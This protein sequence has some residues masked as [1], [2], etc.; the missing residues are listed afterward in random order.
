MANYPLLFGC[1]LLLCIVATFRSSEYY[2]KW[3][4]KKATSSSTAGL[5]E[6]SDHCRTTHN[7]LLK[8]YL[9]VYLTATLSDWFQGPYVY[10]LYMDYGYQPREIAQLFVAGFG[11]SMVF[12][13][14]VGGMADWGGRRAFVLLFVV[15]YSLS[16]ITKRKLLQ[17]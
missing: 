17:Q 2:K 1:A 7:S 12:G 9:F 14:F 6:I 3:V 13:S 4:E 8:R 5:E 10:A 15:V 11:S 16:C